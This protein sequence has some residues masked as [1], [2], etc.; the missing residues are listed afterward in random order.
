M[1]CL[2]TT[3]PSTEPDPTDYNTVCGKDASKVESQIQNLCG[4]NVGAAMTA[5]SS[6]CAAAGKTVGAFYETSNQQ[7]MY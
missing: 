7:Y 3:Y 6:I 1:H 5:F 2:L 4:N